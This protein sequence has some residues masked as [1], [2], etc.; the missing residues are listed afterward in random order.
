MKEIK[1]CIFSKTMN[2]GIWMYLLQFFNLIVPLITLPYITHIL[3][4]SKFGM[5]SVA[6]NIFGYMQVVVEYGFELSATRTVAISKKQEYNE[7]FSAVVYSRLFL[8]LLC[9]IFFLCYMLIY[10]TETLLC[11]C[12]FVLMFGL[13][14]NCFQVN[15]F[16]QGIEKMFYISI[17]SIISRVLS[18]I[19][20]F[21][22][23]K[24]S[25]DLLL[26]CLLYSITPFLIGTLGIL[27]AIRK[28]KLSF[29]LL[30]LSRILIEIKNGFF[31][32]TTQLSGKVFGAIG[33]T[34]LGIFASTQDVGVFSA[35]QKIPNVLVLLWSPIAQIFYPLSSK[36]MNQSFITG[37]I[38]A[39]KLRKVIFPVFTVCAITI[40][41]FAKPII[42]FLFG[43]E[44]LLHYYYIYPLLL[45]LLVSINNNFLG[46][47]ILLA[48]GYDKLYS[49][50]FQL[51]V[52]ATVFINFAAIYFFKGI[53]ASVAP[54]ISEMILWGLLSSKIRTIRRKQSTVKFSE[55]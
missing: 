33:I 26:Y 34:F 29:C 8:T 14:G 55:K 15:W 53:G 6:L 24:N 19:M 30:S 49:S 16:F 32:F 51:G 52:I 46:V 45:W 13:I 1:K 31:V 35:I 18:V 28:F 2:N 12:L 48:G 43:K 17:I 37:E 41:F 39:K 38:Y 42:Q 27:I 10:R 7:I 23:I 50:C 21:T 54:L 40:A 44:Y 47:Q 22:F 5:F 36:Q 3:G 20:I 4:A 11:S 25:D 9:V